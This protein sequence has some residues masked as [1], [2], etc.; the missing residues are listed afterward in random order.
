MQSPNG[1]LQRQTRPLCP[2]VIGDVTERNE[3]AEQPS[4]F[5]VMR[6]P[7][8]A[9]AWI[10]DASTL[11]GLGSQWRPTGKTLTD[12]TQQHQQPHTTVSISERRGMQA[13]TKQTH[14]SRQVH[15]QPHHLQHSIGV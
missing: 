3:E 14:R 12:D 9:A 11:A 2:F 7:P 5:V 15:L 10:L 6:S 4:T 8:T 13:P 1:R